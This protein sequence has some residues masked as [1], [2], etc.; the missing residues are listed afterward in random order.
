M[1][2]NFKKYV[3]DGEAKK[4]GYKIVRSAEELIDYYE[5]IIENIRLYPLK[6]HWMKMTGKAGRR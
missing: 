4:K 6:I 1:I 2:K 3:F 5:D